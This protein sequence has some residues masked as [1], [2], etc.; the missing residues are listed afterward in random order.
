MCTFVYL[1]II[2]RLSI[3]ALF[4]PIKLTLPPGLR[5]HRT[6]RLEC[7]ALNVNTRWI[8]LSLKNF[9][10]LYQLDKAYYRK[11][12]MLLYKLFS[13]GEQSGDNGATK[14]PIIGQ[15]GYTHTHTHTHVHVHRKSLEWRVDASSEKRHDYIFG[16]PMF[17]PSSS[18]WDEQIK[19]IWGNGG[20]KRGVDTR[21]KVIFP[22]GLYFVPGVQNSSQTAGGKKTSNEWARREWSWEFDKRILLRLYRSREN[23]V[24]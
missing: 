8:I 7:I 9:F 21:R 12:I 23:I 24:L 18:S 16:R 20:R 4:I 1:E 3:A 11:N 13:Q 6:I 10:P 22:R 5:I 15:T 17:P 14:W 19:W 2:S